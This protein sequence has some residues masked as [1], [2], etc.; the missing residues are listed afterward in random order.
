MTL[1]NID[2]VIRRAAGELVYFIGTISTDKIKLCTFVPVIEDAD[3]YLEY[4]VHE[5]NYQRPG[6]KARMNLIKRYFEENPNRLVPPIIL[7]GRG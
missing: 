2:H 3:T 6:T 5:N 7:S 4:E 1:G